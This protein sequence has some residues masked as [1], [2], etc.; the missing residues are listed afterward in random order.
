MVEERGQL[1]AISMRAR[2]CNTGCDLVKLREHVPERT[3]EYLW[4]DHLDP[5]VEEQLAH[6]GE[7]DRGINTS[8]TAELTQAVGQ[9]IAYLVDCGAGFGIGGHAGTLAGRSGRH[10]ATVSLEEAPIRN[11]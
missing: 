2:N 4:P 6:S 5:G 10:T 1:C 8:G 3:S 11:Q 7:E 9:G